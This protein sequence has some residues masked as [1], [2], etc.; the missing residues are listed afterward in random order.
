MRLIVFMLI[1]LALGKVGTQTYIRQQS[2]Q[3]T[4]ISAYRE[5]AL[6]ACR[7][8]FGGFNATS[9]SRPSNRSITP[10]PQSERVS[11]EL[12]IGNQN[13]NVRLW[14]T[15]HAQWSA[16]YRDPFLIV[17]AQGRSDRPVCEYDIN[18][19]VAQAHS[20]SKIRASNG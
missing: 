5:P 15:S 1:A 10:P 3:V 12:M 11:I 19:G 8:K 9:A 17:K 16:R 7:K 13:L 20:A 4:I 18:N 6:V 2:A 14:Q